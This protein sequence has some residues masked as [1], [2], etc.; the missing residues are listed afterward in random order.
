MNWRPAQLG[1][2]AAVL[3]GF[4]LVAVDAS[5]LAILG[6]YSYVVVLVFGLVVTVLGG[7]ELADRHATTGDRWRP[8]S[9]ESGY[10]VPVPGDELADLAES[11]LKDRLRRRVVVSLMDARDCSKAD[12]RAQ[13]EDGTWTDDQFAAAYLGN[14]RVQ[15]PITTQLRGLMRRTSTEERARRHVIAALRELRAEGSR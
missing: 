13:V 14:E 6:Q 11:E 2:L 7:L 12:V 8:A 3:V 4:A 15:L 9:T 5:P 1:G 10:R